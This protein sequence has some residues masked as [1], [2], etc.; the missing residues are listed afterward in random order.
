ME[1]GQLARKETDETSAF[2]QNIPIRFFLDTCM[3]MR[4]HFLAEG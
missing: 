4:E 2:R 1:R 3:K